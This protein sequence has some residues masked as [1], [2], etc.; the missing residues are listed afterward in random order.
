MDPKTCVN[1]LFVLELSPGCCDFFSISKAV[2]MDMMPKYLLPAGLDRVV[3]VRQQGARDQDVSGTGDL[4]T[5]DKGT[6]DQGTGDKGTVDKGDFLFFHFDMSWHEI[7][8]MFDNHYEHN[9]RVLEDLRPGD[10]VEIRKCLYS[11]WAIYYGDGKIVHLVGE[12]DDDQI[13]TRFHLKHKF[14]IS[15]KTF[16]KAKVCIDDFWD[17]VGEHKAF[18]NNYDDKFSPMETS[19]ILERANKSIGRVGYNVLYSNCEHFATWCR[20]DVRESS[21]VNMFINLS[22]GIFVM[23]LV[24][25]FQRKHQGEIAHVTIAITRFLLEIDFRLVVVLPYIMASVYLKKSYMTGIPNDQISQ[26]KIKTMVQRMVTLTKATILITA[27]GLE[28]DSRMVLLYVMV[29]ECLVLSVEIY[30]PNTLVQRMF[31]SLTK[32]LQRLYNRQFHFVNKLAEPARLN[33]LLLQLFPIDQI[34]NFDE[35]AYEP[36]YFKDNLKNIQSTTSQSKPEIVDHENIQSETIQLPIIDLHKHLIDCMK[37]PGHRQFIP[38]DRFTLN[39]LPEGHHDIDLYALIKV[40][41]DLTVRVDVKMTSPHRIE[42]WPNTK[43]SYPFYNMKC[44]TNLRCGSGMVSGRVYKFTDGY[45]QYGDKHRK[46]YTTCWCKKCQNSDTASHVWWEFHVVTAPYIVFDDIEASHTSLKLF[47]ERENRPVVIVDQV[48]VVDVN[49]ERD[50]CKLSCVT[51]DKNLGDK[52]N[53]LWE[54]YEDISRR[55]FYKYVE[56]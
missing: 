12:D 11:H 8:T 10:R 53:M 43:V 35:Q 6:G 30:I 48:S 18:I 46:N 37:N 24:N 49:I 28:I 17:V 39:H 26:R 3:Y 42:F 54:Y 47:Y 2:A 14:T 9:K 5:G 16:N 27:V 22:V 38:V 36:F 40:T 33:K 31:K 50:M 25:V 7:I 41:A 13:D 29:S 32:K 15:G 23:I 1:H 19:K 52:L 20:Y 34:E 45:R 4:G 21:Q 56:S 55:V 44:K 51:C